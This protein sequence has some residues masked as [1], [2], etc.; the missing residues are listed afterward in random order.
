MKLHTALALAATLGS[1]AI[2]VPLTSAPALACTTTGMSACNTTSVTVAGGGY[3]VTADAGSKIAATLGQT[4]G[5][6]LPS[7]VWADNTGSGAGWKGTVQVSTLNYT[8]A[9]TPNGTPTGTLST[10]AGTY[11][12]TGDGVYY[13]VKVT[14]VSGSSSVTFSWSSTDPT[15]ST[16]GTGVTATVGSPANVGTQ[17]VQIT[18]ATL[19]AVNDSWTV[20]VGNQN[21]SALSVTGATIA[22]LTGVTSPSPTFVAPNTVIPAGGVGSFGTAVK[23]LDAQVNQGMGSYT[24]IPSVNLSLDANSWQ[25]TYTAD[26]QYTIASGP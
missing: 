11:K 3:S 12:G 26:V 8:G 6:S 5:G 4:V 18:F 1:A 13:T 14:S 15:D 24:V 21:A 17:G 22:P 20:D 16:G 23:F 25:G 19:P 10:G 2:A 7:A 9:W